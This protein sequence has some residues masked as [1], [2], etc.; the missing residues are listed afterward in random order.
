MGSFKK[1]GTKLLQRQDM[2]SFLSKSFYKAFDLGVDSQPM[3]LMELHR[4]ACPCIP[5]GRILSSGP[6]SPAAS[7]PG[8][9]MSV[10]NKSS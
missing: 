9:N 2:D 3:T 5:R 1:V 4:V 6:F 10:G 7:V 8:M